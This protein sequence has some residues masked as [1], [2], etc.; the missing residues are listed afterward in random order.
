MQTIDGY[1]FPARGFMC[2]VSEKRCI[3]AFFRYQRRSDLLF[4]VTL[5]SSLS[6]NQPDGM[7]R[8]PDRI[9]IQKNSYIQNSIS[10]GVRCHSERKKYWTSPAD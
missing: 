4:Q 10:R 2:P 6:E 5:K 8:T 9:G 3:G 1:H 7:F